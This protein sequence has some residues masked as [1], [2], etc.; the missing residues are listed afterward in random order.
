MSLINELYE[1]I[2]EELIIDKERKTPRISYNFSK[3]GLHEVLFFFNMKLVNST[4]NM[5]SD[6]SNLI[7][8][9]VSQQQENK[10]IKNMSKM[11]K[12][13]KNLK[14]VNFNN[15]VY[16]NIIDLSYMFC[17]CIS[18]TSLDLPIFLSKNTENIRYMFSNC[19]SL[20][21]LSFSSFETASIKD[22]SGL[23]Y[24]CSS[25]TSID[26]SDFVT[27]NLIKINY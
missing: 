20:K 4:E 3:S 21:S 16:K 26:L 15:N 24:G 14:V 12:N 13:C 9:E 2:I 18:L 19:K 10:I 23:F 7:F 17:N 25:L 27:T 6:I 8:F 1:N 22:M 11:F 5:F